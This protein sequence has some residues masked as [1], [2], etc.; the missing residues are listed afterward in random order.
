[1]QDI[2]YKKILSIKYLSMILKILFTPYPGNFSTTTKYFILYCAHRRYTT[3]KK[4]VTQQ[5]HVT[6]FFSCQWVD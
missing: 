1:M 2:L 4:R 3:D 6:N 5:T